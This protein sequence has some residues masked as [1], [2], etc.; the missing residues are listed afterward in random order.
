MFDD[1]KPLSL[2]Q[3]IERLRARARDM[4]IQVNHLQRMFPYSEIELTWSDDPEM[5]RL[6]VRC[7]ELDDAT[8]MD[9]VDAFVI[10]TL[11]RF[12]DI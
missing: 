6:L 3:K 4:G 12:A 1:P 2:K 8:T 10:N 9:Q 5:K 11:K 7:T